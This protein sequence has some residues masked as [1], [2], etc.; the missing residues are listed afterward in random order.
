MAVQLERFL[1]IAAMPRSLAGCGVP[2]TAI[3]MLAEEAARQWTAG[4]NPRKV[5]VEDFVD[6]YAAAFATR[7]AG[8]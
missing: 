6:L 1:N 3:P 5:T 4:F 8:A 2:R 7:A